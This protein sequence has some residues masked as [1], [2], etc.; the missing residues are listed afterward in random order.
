M[1]ERGRRQ[2]IECCKCFER[3]WLRNG[4]P[5]TSS[6]TL[7][8]GVCADTLKKSRF[9]GSHRVWGWWE[10]AFQDG[11]ILIHGVEKVNVEGATIANST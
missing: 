7:L 1:E 10:M 9:T 8:G 5:P 3:E 2:L 11:G 6:V 4:A